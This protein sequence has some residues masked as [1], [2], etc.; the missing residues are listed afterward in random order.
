MSRKDKGFLYKVTG[1][2]SDFY[3]IMGK[4]YLAPT[5]RDAAFAFIDEHPNAKHVWVWAREVAYDVEASL[6]EV[7]D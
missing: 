3:P 2:E 5:A 1:Q 7:D 4:N 6:R